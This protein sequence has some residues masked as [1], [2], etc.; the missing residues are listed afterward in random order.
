PDTVPARFRERRL[1][2]HNASVTLMR[3]SVEE[4]RELGRILARKVNAATGP[5]TVFIPRGGVSMIDVPGGAFHDPAADA[6]LF[7][8]L[9]ADLDPR[10]EVVDLAVDINDPTFGPA[11]ADRLD[12]L[13]RAGQPLA[14][15]VR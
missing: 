14:S 11:M 8:A 12:A 10:V 7:D 2:E 3:T 4:C 5:T 6:A 13:L 9:H 15:T 1:Y